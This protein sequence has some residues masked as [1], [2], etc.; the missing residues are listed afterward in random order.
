MP[1]SACQSVCVP[2]CPAKRAQ[3]GRIKELNKW[4]AAVV[5]NSPMRNHKFVSSL[6]THNRCTAFLE[7]H[8]LRFDTCGGVRV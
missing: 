8:L 7:D 3:K 4:P 6:L 5:L 1:R 2:S